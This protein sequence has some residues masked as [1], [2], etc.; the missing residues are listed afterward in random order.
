M[1]RTVDL[2]VAAFQPECSPPMTVAWTNVVVTDT[3]HGVTTKL[4]GTF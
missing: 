1:E 4:P 3:E 2:L